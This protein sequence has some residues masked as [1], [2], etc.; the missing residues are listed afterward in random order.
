MLII[1]EKEVPDFKCLLVEYYEENNKEAIFKF[2]K[3]SALK[4]SNS[5]MRDLHDYPL[6]RI[7]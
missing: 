2:M 5:F 1:P 4:R 6:V 3:R 7:A